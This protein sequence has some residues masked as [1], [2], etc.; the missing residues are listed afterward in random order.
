[1]I[2][3]IYYIQKRPVK[4]KILEELCENIDTEHT[5]LLFHTEIGWLLRGKLLN[6]ELERQY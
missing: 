6:R 4:C 3:Q 1:V 2:E 5:T